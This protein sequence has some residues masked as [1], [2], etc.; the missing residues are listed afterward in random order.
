MSNT[1]SMYTK[2]VIDVQQ[3]WISRHSLDALWTMVSYED[4]N[5]YHCDSQPWKWY[6]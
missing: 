3:W 1:E 4:T 5:I 2:H 6:A